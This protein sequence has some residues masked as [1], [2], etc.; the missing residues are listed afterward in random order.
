MDANVIAICA[1]TIQQTERSGGTKVRGDILAHVISELANDRRVIVF[2]QDRLKSMYERLPR[3]EHSPYDLLNAKTRPAN[4]TTIILFD[5][6]SDFSLSSLLQ[7]IDMIYI[8]NTPKLLERLKKKYDAPQLLLGD[9][10]NIIIGHRHDS[11]YNWSW[12]YTNLS[13]MKIRASV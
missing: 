4:I 8:H 12:E 5:D 9:P 10:I 7:K 13:F 1:P 3:C 11:E 6:V 2:Y